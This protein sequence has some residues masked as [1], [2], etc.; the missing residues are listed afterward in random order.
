V[1]LMESGLSDGARPG[2]VDIKASEILQMLDYWSLNKEVK[3]AGYRDRTDDV[4]GKEAPPRNRFA[5]TEVDQ[6]L[7]GDADHQ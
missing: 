3:K 4:E 1:K 7:S 5:D 6:G 2:S